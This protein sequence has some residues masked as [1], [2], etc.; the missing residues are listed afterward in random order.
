[1]SED[2]K[3][4]RGGYNRQ[5]FI[6]TIQSLMDKANTRKEKSLESIF[7]GI[8]GQQMMAPDYHSRSAYKT[9][10]NA[11]PQNKSFRRLVQDSTSELSFLNILPI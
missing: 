11:S 2:E 9:G 10:T 8:A 1:M 7:P 6:G 3:L 4:Q 5:S